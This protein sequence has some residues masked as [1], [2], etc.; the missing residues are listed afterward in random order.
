MSSFQWFCLALRIIGA[1]TLVN[2]L[3]MLG[4]AFNVARGHSSGGFDASAYVSQAIWHALI[5]TVLIGLAPTLARVVYGMAATPSASTS[6][7]DTSA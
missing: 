3:E 1:W 5:A 4:T 6:T 2:G 7:T